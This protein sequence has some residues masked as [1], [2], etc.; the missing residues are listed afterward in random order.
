MW[1]DFSLKTFEVNIIV[2][3]FIP[4]LIQIFMSQNRSVFA[5]GMNTLDEPKIASDFNSIN[6]M[7]CSVEEF[8]KCFVIILS[9]M[10]HS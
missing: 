8:K 9:R 2:L 7:R 10:V 3:N 5:Q 4:I 1:I 6:H